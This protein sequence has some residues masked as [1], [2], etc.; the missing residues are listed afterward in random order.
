MICV[1]CV[2]AARGNTIP[3]SDY[4]S[5]EALTAVDG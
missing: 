1:I 3:I 2:S 4:I 5:G